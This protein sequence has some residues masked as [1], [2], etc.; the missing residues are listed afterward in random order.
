MLVDM[1]K[2]LED[3]VFT[4]LNAFSTAFIAALN[5][6]A[7]IAYAVANTFSDKSFTYIIESVIMYFII[8][9]IFSSYLGYSFVEAV[10]LS[11][12]YPFEW[13]KQ[14]YSNWLG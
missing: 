4:F 14:L 12:R 11:I 5:P 1:G 2:L 10:M 13:I 8:M 6:I 7:G 9:K 3:A